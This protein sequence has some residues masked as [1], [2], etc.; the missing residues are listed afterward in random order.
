MVMSSPPAAAASSAK[1]T[2]TQASTFKVV[3]SGPF[4]TALAKKEYFVLG[5]K[6]RAIGVA[7]VVY[8]PGAVI[9][10]VLGRT[11]TVS[12]VRQARL[13]GVSGR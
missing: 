11:H 13:S 10:D 3:D 8:G 5:L 7:K 2:R 9:R 6:Q 1:P 12:N 4:G